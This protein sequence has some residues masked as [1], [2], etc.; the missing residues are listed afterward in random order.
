MVRGAIHHRERFSGIT[1]C[2]L[3]YLTAGTDSLT[4]LDPKRVTCKRCKKGMGKID[5]PRTKPS[6]AKGGA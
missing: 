1:K 4:T 3:H 6:D 5:E 2:G